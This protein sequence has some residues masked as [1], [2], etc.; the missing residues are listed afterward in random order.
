[1]EKKRLSKALAAA[2][3]ASRRACEE[4]I[5]GGRV[6]VNGQ[7]VLIPQTLV[8]LEEDRVVVDGSLVKA[9]QKK[10]CYVLNKPKGIICSSA[11]V[12]RKPII[13]DLFPASHERLFTVGR[14]DKDSTG[15]LLVTNDGHFAQKVIH[16]SSKITKEY[17]VKTMHE[18]TP[19][20]LESLAQGARIDEKWVRPVSVQKVRRGTF[21]ICVKEGKKHEVRIIAE[22]AGLKV[23]ELTRIRIGGLLLGSLPEGEYRPLTDKDR[24]LLFQTDV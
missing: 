14:L 3:I 1:M 6:Q 5:F 4:L 9:E 7:T 21:K 13:L 17:L 22:R 18:I 15:L 10:V 11:R 8:D 24:Q 20:H 23:M 19:E 2:G 16:P 12:G